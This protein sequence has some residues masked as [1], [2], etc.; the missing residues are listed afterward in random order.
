MM[1]KMLMLQKHGMIAILSAQAMLVSPPRFEQVASS[2]LT[3][4]SFLNPYHKPEPTVPVFASCKDYFK[5]MWIEI[6][7][8]W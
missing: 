7:K 2:F 4:V 1:E 5:Y 3:S 6:L 8:K